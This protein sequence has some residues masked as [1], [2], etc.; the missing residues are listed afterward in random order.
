[1]PEY[2]YYLFMVTT[3]S[4]IHNTTFMNF[5]IESVCFFSFISLD[6]EGF[7]HNSGRN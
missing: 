5:A 4:L 3:K 6:G 1:M 2:L 7:G